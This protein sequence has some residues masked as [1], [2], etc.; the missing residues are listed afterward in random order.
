M[1]A[2]EVGQSKTRFLSSS[3]VHKHITTWFFFY[4]Q[5][6]VIYYIIL[7]LYKITFVIEMLI[8]KYMTRFT[9]LSSQPSADLCGGEAG[10]PPPP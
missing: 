9:E 8:T 7:P 6:F 1:L 2:G 4:L 5:L 3:V 10:S